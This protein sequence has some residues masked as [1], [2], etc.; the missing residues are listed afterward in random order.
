MIQQLSPN[1]RRAV[2]FGAGA[3][4]VY[5]AMVLGSLAELEAISGLKPFDLRPTGYGPNDARTL[6]VSLGET[7]REIYL[8]HQLVLDTA[9][10]ALLALTLSNLFRLV[11]QGFGVGV[12]VRIGVVL[13][14]L[15]AALDYAENIGIAAML[16][17][18]ADLPNA[19]ATATSLA[20]VA[21]S[22]STSVAVTTLLGLLALR[23]WRFRRPKFQA[24]PKR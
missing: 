17:L 22:V 5:I 20:T 3:A 13:S 15:T 12:S 1:A 11:G 21:K 16:A 24:E 9:Y 14:W 4:T 2:V 23:L 19:L 8:R 7:G 10:P 18:W 6:L